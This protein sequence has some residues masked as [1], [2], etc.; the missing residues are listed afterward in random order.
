MDPRLHRY[1]LNFS[2]GSQPIQVD[3]PDTRVFRNCSSYG[4]RVPGLSWNEFCIHHQGQLEYL[5][6]PKQVI[7]EAIFDAIDGEELYPVAYERGSR[8]DKFLARA[9]KPAIDKLFAQ[10]LCL[11][12]STGASIQ[13]SVQL[14]VAANSSKQIS[15]ALLISQEVS[16]LM[17]R[18]EVHNGVRGVLNLSNFGAN[19]CF[20]SIVVS[21]ANVATL[22]HVC[23]SIY[24]NDDSF[25][26]VNGFIFADNQ[27]KS[28]DPLK[29]FGDVEYGLLDLS[30]NKI[31]SAVRLCR[32]LKRI[33]A[34]ELKLANNPITKSSRYPN[35]IKALQGNFSM[36]DGIPYDKLH[37]TYTPL[38]HDIDLES[39]GI[40]I[41]WTNKW[42]L[43]DFE[44]SEDWHAFLVPDRMHLM[45]EQRLF[46]LF[47][48]TANQMLA[49]IYP[50]YYKFDGKEHIFLARNCF[51]QIEYLVH[52]CNLEMK[53]PDAEPMV[54]PDVRVAPR[55]IPFYMRMN[56][57]R[58]KLHHV[59]PQERIT[60]CIQKCFVA[61][62]RVL[63]M[64][65]FQATE[66]LKGLWVHMGSTRILNNIL[67]IISRLY[68]S[69]CSEIRLCN[70]GIL[71]IDGARVL[72]RMG[73]LRALDLG[74]N[75]IHDLEDIKSLGDLPLKSLRLHGNPLCAK[76][77]L[78]NDY[79]QA[80]L[81]IFPQLTTLDG[82]DLSSKPGQAPQKNFLCDIGAYE[83]LGDVFLRNYLREFEQADERANHLMKYY[84]DDS[85]F[86]MTCNYVMGR[87]QSFNAQLFKRIA[88]YTKHSRD[89]RKWSDY[90]KATN[91][92]HVG[93]MEIIGVLMELPS[94]V[95]DF[96]SLQ[97]DVMH[98]N[99]KSAVIHV[100]GL[101]RD[102]SPCT[103]NQEE[104]YLA[105]SRDFVLKIDDQGKGFGKESRRL[106]IVNDHLSIMN[107]S[108][109][110]LKSAF[111]V[112]PLPDVRLMTPAS[113]DSIDAKN[114]KL[115]IFLELTGLTSPWCTR[116]V[117]TA[118]WDFE[119]AT[120]LFLDMV[121]KKELPDSAFH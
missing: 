81:K 93:V 40:R 25:S 120:K 85:I 59:D 23:S 38:N 22:R 29:L 121:E 20:K 69:N 111:K 13:I 46:R 74:H 44:Q 73:N 28:V 110:Q 8:V 66:G 32:E 41:D 83:M 62:N 118:E 86:T 2:D 92:F 35:S 27:M 103:H 80:V 84:T 1:V 104:L 12:I 72:S 57:S 4:D 99:G 18:L 19:P 54:D 68:M 37:T 5:H 102:D 79:I 78:P 116:I 60:K 49:E 97:T 106:Q 70:N 88:K 47:F 113:E 6:D 14:G 107:P 58:F 15:P 101:L 100:T 90:T 39:D 17:E 43:A 10:K 95:H 48:S 26:S 52:S 63:K 30:G 75:W 115:I 51:E 45:T 98:F 94:V 76:Y 36:V 31:A 53:L 117:E 96:V 67:S 89:I 65:H 16:R 61:Q 108:R 77:S 109:H 9:C 114:D 119:L 3:Y 21:L 71:R 11:S 7:L 55:T 64:S 87:S 34:K 50:C 24:H 33:R 112:C 91:E 56:V 42:K 105:F 82:V